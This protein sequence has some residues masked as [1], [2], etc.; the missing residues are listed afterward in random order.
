M[1]VSPDLT[2]S[3]YAA[4]PALDASIVASVVWDERLH[5]AT[6][7]R[8]FRSEKVSAFV[9][10][11]LDCDEPRRKR[12]LPRSEAVSD[13]RHAGFDARKILDP[14]SR[15]RFRTIWPRRLIAGPTP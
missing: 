4:Q 2:D 14:S 10:A 7:M 13:R 1:Y 3:E 15:T 9:K 12:Y 8:S 11:V 5:L 6:S